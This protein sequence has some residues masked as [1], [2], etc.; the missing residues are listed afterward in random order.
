MRY[1][2][3]GPQWRIQSW[4]RMTSSRKNFIYFIYFIFKCHQ[5]EMY[6][7]CMRTVC[8]MIHY[9]PSMRNI[10][11]KWSVKVYIIFPP[12]KTILLPWSFKEPS[13]FSRF[14]KSAGVRDS[15]PDKTWSLYLEYYHAVGAAYR[16]LHAVNA[17]QF[18]ALTPHRCSEAVATSCF[19]LQYFL[20][21]KFTNR[22][23]PAKGFVRMLFLS[24]HVLF[25]KFIWL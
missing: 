12:R 7:I 16:W 8:I 23:A 14:F 2:G 17:S 22:Q 3:P 20:A 18:L 4:K 10:V 11:S 9:H 19:L 15:V 5:G 1:G 13:R 24:Y 21:C 6:R 25:H